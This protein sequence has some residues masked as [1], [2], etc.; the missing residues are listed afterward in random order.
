[1]YVIFWV[2]PRRP[3]VVCRLFG[4]LCQFHLQGLDV[5]Y[6]ILYIQ[7]LKMELI[8]GSETSANHNRTPGKYPKEYIDE[9][10]ICSLQSWRVGESN[11]LYGVTSQQRVICRISWLTSCLSWPCTTLELV[12]RTPTKICLLKCVVFYRILSC[13]VAGRR[14]GD[15]G[16]ADGEQVPWRRQL[17]VKEAGSSYHNQ[18]QATG[19]P[20]DSF[21]ADAETH[22]AHTGTAGEGDRPAHEGHTGRPSV[23][24]YSAG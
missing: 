5:K 13:R 20:E 22:Q 10:N 21:L 4:T 2:F 11:K 16:F 14:P 23:H 7:P 6:F 19:N 9:S 17:G 12:K 24:T 1:M 15:A 18:G 3:I 8:E